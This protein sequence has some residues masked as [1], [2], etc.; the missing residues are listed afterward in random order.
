MEE[1][2]SSGGVWPNHREPCHAR[3]DG[4]WVMLHPPLSDAFAPRASRGASVA[5]CRRIKK[6][7]C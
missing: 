3:K 4:W 6:V 7:E 2:N 1:R 5:A